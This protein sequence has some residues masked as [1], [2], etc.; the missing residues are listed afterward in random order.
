[1]RKAA[2]WTA[3]YPSCPRK[4]VV[5]LNLANQLVTEGLWDGEDGGTG[6]SDGLCRDGGAGKDKD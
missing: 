4:H 1:M 5:F 3:S 2:G 6:G